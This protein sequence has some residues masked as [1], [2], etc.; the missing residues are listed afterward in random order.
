L[1]RNDFTKVD[2][3]EVDIKRCHLAKNLTVEPRIAHKSKHIEPL[4]KLGLGNR[5]I[6]EA[7]LVVAYLIF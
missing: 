5:A 6:L 3:S 4:K 2:W 7:T 1:L